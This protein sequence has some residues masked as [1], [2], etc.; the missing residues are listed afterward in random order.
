VTCYR[1]FNFDDL[2]ININKNIRSDLRKI[3]RLVF[4]IG[5]DKTVFR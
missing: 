3:Q 5:Y 2:L 1:N 4:I